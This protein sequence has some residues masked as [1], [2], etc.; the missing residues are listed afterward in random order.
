MFTGRLAQTTQAYP[1][2]SMG[3][4]EA[5]AQFFVSHRGRTARDAQAYE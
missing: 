5:T 4:Q 2:W 3:I 1:T